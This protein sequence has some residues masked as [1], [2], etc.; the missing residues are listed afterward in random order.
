MNHQAMLR[1]ALRKG[2]QLSSDAWFSNPYRVS[3]FCG[4]KP[5]SSK[6]TVLFLVSHC[7]IWIATHWQHLSD[8]DLAICAARG[9]LSFTH[10]THLPSHKEPNKLRRF[11]SQLP[12]QANAPSHWG[13]RL[14]RWQDDWDRPQLSAWFP[15]NVMLF[16]SRTRMNEVTRR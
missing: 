5:S 4:C 8:L 16:Q 14:C 10:F 1:D 2:T 3:E 12:F 7:G 9:Q 15:A 11:T 13:C 6:W